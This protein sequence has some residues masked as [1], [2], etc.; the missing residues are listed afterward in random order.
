M[1]RATVT[2]SALLALL[3]AFNAQERSTAND[4]LKPAPAESKVDRKLASAPDG[5]W[6]TL[7]GQFVYRA[8]APKPKSRDVKEA[9]RIIGGFVTVK[10]ESLIVSEKGGVAN[11]LIYVTSANIP[12]HPSYLASKE[13]KVLLDVEPWRFAPRVLAFRTSQP[14]VLRNSTEH[15]QSFRVGRVGNAM[16]NPLVASKSSA[17]YTF[18]AP[19]ATPLAI[20]NDILPWMHA[21]LLPLNHPYAAVSQTDGSFVISKLPVGTWEFQVWH[22]TS[23]LFHAQPWLKGRFTTTIK[24]GENDL[25]TITVGKLTTSES[26]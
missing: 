18:V 13:A 7:S 15:P 3:I 12:V 21:Y 8:D 10:D 6:G 16:I 25:G 9:S 19:Q 5:D 22:E 17:E 26:R 11:V 1:S 24:R 14:V 20:S 2:S 4:D 23:G